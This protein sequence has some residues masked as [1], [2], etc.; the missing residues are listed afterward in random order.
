MIDAN[1]KLLFFDKQRIT[2]PA[3][4]AKLRNLSKFGAYVMRSARRS[5]KGKA[6]P[7]AP[8][9]PPHAHA[10]YVRPAVQ[11]ADGK[12]RKAQKR[13]NFRDSILFGYDAA[14]DVTVVGPQFKS[15]GKRSPTMPQL[16]EFGG[17]GQGAGRTIRVLNKPGRDAKGRFVTGGFR[18]IKLD[19]TLRY[20]KRPFMAPA[21]AKELPKFVGLFRASI[22]GG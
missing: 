9:T 2:D 10:F 18:E 3:E 8:G 16:H 12:T 6:G 15:G 11:K 21:L 1:F 19:G 17:T 13:F 7:S 14:R 4:K 5:I 20:P 22:S